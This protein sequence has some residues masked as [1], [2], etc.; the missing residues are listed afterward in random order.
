MIVATAGHIDHG[1]TS[2]VRALTGVDTDRLPEEKN[3]GISI[4]LGFAYLPI[5]GG[6][7]IGFV[8]VPGHE[9]FV[10]NMIAGVSGIDFA[11]VVVAADDG[12]MPQTVEHVQILDLLGISSA[13]IV[14]T[15]IDRVDAARVSEVG[16]QVQ[17]LLSGTSLAGADW[18]PVSALNGD[19][20]GALRDA[21]IVAAQ[22]SASRHREGRNFRLSIDRAFTIKGSGTV[23]TG[24]VFDGKTVPGDHFVVTPRGTE[25]RIRQIQIRGQ[26]AERVEA[27]QRCALNLVGASVEEVGRGEWVLA[28]AINLPARRLEVR[29]TLLAGASEPLAH[30]TSVDVHIATARVRARVALDARNPLRPGETRVVQLVLDREIVAVHGDRFILRET[31]GRHTQGGGIVLDPFAPATRRS[32]PARLAYVEALQLGTPEAAMDCLLGMP[33]VAVDMARFDAT[34]N[35]TLASSSAICSGRNAI[36]LGRDKRYALSASSVASLCGSILKCLSEFHRTTPAAPAM[37]IPKLRK[38]AAPHLPAPAFVALLQRLGSEGKVDVQNSTVRLVD[39][40][41]AAN[42]KDDAAW[43]RMIEVLLGHGFAPPAL[44]ALAEELGEPEKVIKD[45]L[46]RK[47]TTGEVLR[48]PGDRL[49]P[50]ATMATLAATAAA[51]AKASPQGTFS[52]AEYRDATGINRT[53]AIQV[54]EFL[55]SLG[56]TRR[57]GD[58]RKV[59]KDPAP[60][61]GDAKPAPKPAILPAENHAARQPPAGAKKSAPFTKKNNWR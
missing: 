58:V 46:F 1:K 44:P 41:E 30:W 61:L 33:D 60:I 9:R 31:S 18:L 27:G 52:A 21:L 10:R 42:S 49:Y 19:G 39:R 48:I 8:D 13:L 3:R 4:D 29:C 16:A 43:R 28:A 57:S 50:R 53:L 40:G 14:V 34:F 55:D 6:G 20:V 25:V 47:R 38:A 45:L 17:S 56:I 5:D 59:W 7:L 32:T 12:V 11:L 23:V 2:L 37:D 26:V 51:V 24:T 54:L 22:K 36:V 15:K 35:L